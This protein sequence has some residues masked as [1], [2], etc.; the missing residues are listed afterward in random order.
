[1][2][3]CITHQVPEFLTDYGPLTNHMI[4]S[5]NDKEYYIKSIYPKWGFS[6]VNTN[7]KG[8]SHCEEETRIR[9]CAFR[10]EPKE[11][12]SKAVEY[13]KYDFTDIRTHRVDYGTDRC[14][15]PIIGLS[16]TTDEDG[17]SITPSTPITKATVYPSPVSADQ[18]MVNL[19][20]VSDL[21][22]Q[23]GTIRVFN[24]M[25]QEVLSSDV[26]LLEGQN[27]FQFE[28]SNFT[29]G[30]YLVTISTQDQLIDRVKFIKN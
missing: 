16:E 6:M 29:K 8:S 27:K 4:R 30:I 18:A 10:T 7:L 24:S 14:E 28:V 1:M 19:Q 20:F 5:S 9:I 23:P 25:G 11:E 2:I 15:D 26:R 21:E 13:G 22:A 3:S 12:R 17:G